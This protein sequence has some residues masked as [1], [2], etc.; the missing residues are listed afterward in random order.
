MSDADMRIDTLRLRELRIPFKTAFRH[1]S[2]SRAAT[3]SVWVEALA[4]GDIV[5]QGEACPRPY[6]TQETIESA[7]AFVS[8]HG[9]SICDR[10][11][12]FESLRTWMEEHLE[13]ID[14]NPAA[15][16]SVELACL[17]AVGRSRGQTIEAVLGLP[18][19]S[20]T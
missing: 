13:D 3:S 18:P 1:A 5:G 9:E 20:G 7:S 12:D 15:W 2:A 11:H 14:A 19:L 4:A 17:D 8:T 6:V 10:I 16:C